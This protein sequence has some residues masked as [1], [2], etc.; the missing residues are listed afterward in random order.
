MV[1][2]FYCDSGEKTGMEQNSV[3]LASFRWATEKSD[4]QDDT[5]AEDADDT[6]EKAVV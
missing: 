6:E 5:V 2:T 1:S 3:T 4:A